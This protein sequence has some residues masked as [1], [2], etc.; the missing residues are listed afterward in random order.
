MQDNSTAPAPASQP[1]VPPAPTRYPRLSV[2]V[3]FLLGLVALLITPYLAEQIVYA[4]SRG[5]ARAE[6]EAALEL[7]SQLPAP[8]NRYRWV[9]KAIAPSVVAVEMVRIVPGH[10]LGDEWTSLFQPPSAVAGQGS[11]VIVDKEGY[12]VTNFHVVNGASEIHVTLSDGEEIRNVEFVGADP[13]SDV[14]VLKI[15]PGMRK[16]VS[17]NWGDSD[18]LEVG[19]PVLAI[20]SPYGFAQ[21]VTAG[22]VSG[23]NRRVVDA[24]QTLALNFLQTDA[25]VNPGNSGGPLVNLKGEIVGINT[26]IYGPRYQGIAFAIPSRP[27]QEVYDKLK[28]GET[29]PRGWLGVAMQEVTEPLAEQLGLEQARGA[30]VR[31]VVAG[32]PAEKAGIKVGDVMVKWGDKAVNDTHDLR[33]LVAST[34]AGTRVKVELIRDGRKQEVTVTVAQ[35]QPQ[36]GR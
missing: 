10:R 16:L 35:R 19:D 31:G 4:I 6:A 12:I 13:P 5:K 33:L 34:Q 25:A 2:M 11:G 36:F 18:K 1:P 22:I 30:L 14:A 3:V 9:V 24:G 7:L 28:A 15:S 32:S 20:G 29:V 26:A 23:K 27:A 21:T 8:E 17:A